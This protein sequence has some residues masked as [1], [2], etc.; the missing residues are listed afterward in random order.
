LVCPYRA[1]DDNLLNA[2]VRR[3][4][5]LSVD[6]AVHV[7]PVTS[8]ADP[9]TRAQFLAAAADPSQPRQF[10][11]FQQLFGGEVGLSRT[12]ASPELSF[13]STVVEVVP[14]P[15]PPPGV[16]LTDTR[17]PRLVKPGRYG[18]IEIQTADTHGSYRHAV[19][20]LNSALDL[21]RSGGFAEQV[22]AHP[23]WP[24]RRI[25]GPNISNVFKRT[26]YQVMVKFQITRRD[27]S[28]GCVLAIPQPVWD[29]WQ[30]F[31]GSPHL[32]DRG[33][34]TF[35]LLA[36]G[37][38]ARDDP[39]LSGR[40]PQP[41]NWVYVFDVDEQPPSSGQPTPVTITAVIGTDAPSLSRMALD[42]APARAAELGGTQDA[43]ATAV[44]RRLARYAPE[45]M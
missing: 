13:D 38:H 5:G 33:D 27:T 34:G 6:D 23:D 10:L 9:A 40:Q 1:L 28:A 30:P 44:R 17:S 14:D 45:L 7:L 25:E 15:D 22:A 3:L 2:M 20:A 35:R 42:V 43:V 36:A 26:F 8:L 11:V 37:D 18:I 24:A 12:H 29:S 19:E 39:V 41:P 4:Y 31:L 32:V 16:F 21:H